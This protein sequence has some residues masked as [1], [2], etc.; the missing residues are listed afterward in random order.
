M[1]NLVPVAAPYKKDQK[2]SHSTGKT[3]MD[4]RKRHGVRTLAGKRLAELCKEGK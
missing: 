1:I 4:I 2:Q 3:A